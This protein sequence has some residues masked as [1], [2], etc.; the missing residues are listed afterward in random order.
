MK[1]PVSKA[2][3][4]SKTQPAVLGWRFAFVLVSISAP[5]LLPW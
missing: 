3:A 4:K 5:S 1:R 2:Q